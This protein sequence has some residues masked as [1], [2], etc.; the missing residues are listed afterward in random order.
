MIHTGELAAVATANPGPPWTQ[1]ILAVITLA[2][3]LYT[4]W[5][6][7]RGEHRSQD[8]DRIEGLW[9]RLDALERRVGELE[10]QN[11]S[12][13]NQINI[14]RTLV[15]ALRGYASRLRELLIDNKISPPDPPQGFYG[16]DH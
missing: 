8:W 16:D 6:A 13:Q 11:L 7:S 9:G 4:G 5:R 2:G 12:E 1:I 10:E 3:V 14:L 15:N